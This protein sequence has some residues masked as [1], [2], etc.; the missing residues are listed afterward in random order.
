M[1]HLTKDLTKKFMLTIPF[2]DLLLLVK[3]KKDNLA[4]D[5]YINDKNFWKNLLIRDYNLDTIKNPK[6]KP[7]QLYIQIYHYGG[8]LQ[9]I[10]N[11]SYKYKL[12]GF[13]DKT[14][15]LD[16][17]ELLLNSKLIDPLFGQYF[18]KI[19]EPELYK[20]GKL[21][22]YIMIKKKLELFKICLK[23]ES[24]YPILVH[25]IPFTIYTEY[26]SSSMIKIL[27]NIDNYDFND[28]IPISNL[29]YGGYGMFEAG[30]KNNYDVVNYLLTNEKY[31]SLSD[32]NDIINSG[33]DGTLE[34]NSYETARLLINTA[35]EK[36]INININSRIAEE[37]T[38][39]N[40]DYV[41][42]LLE[43][44]FLDPSI[45]TYE[46]RLPIIRALY[47]DS[48]DLVKLLLND[49]RINFPLNNEYFIALTNKMDPLNKSI[50]RLYLSDDRMSSNGLNQQY[51]LYKNEL[52]TRKLWT[53]KRLDMQSDN[54]IQ[55]FCGDFEGNIYK[56]R[57]NTLDILLTNNKV[58]P[59]NISIIKDIIFRGYY[60]T[61]D[62]TLIKTLN[63]MNIPK[64]DYFTHSCAALFL[65]YI[66]TKNEKTL[67]ILLKMLPI[68]VKNDI[69]NWLNI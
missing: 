53:I 6:I 58:K 26:G 25:E 33:L 32:I 59:N 57:L 64:F 66:C 15:S 63:Q 67:N 47:S 13:F 43:F 54:N 30:S 41:K 60:L 56:L 10:F 23:N 18:R 9:K 17:F 69:K 45:L 29:E 35:N 11:K 28:G 2:E 7:R 49:I 31:L 34:N 61:D 55:A 52:L 27:V 19:R 3:S 12:D 48:Y 40:T 21:I 46:D 5:I 51:I 68:Y 16:I 65:T 62:N 14:L 20:Y 22:K 1:D 37:C 24:L 36:N 50:I 44:R 39:G 8:N 42:F 4:L 38:S